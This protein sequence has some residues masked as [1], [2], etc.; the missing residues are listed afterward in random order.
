MERKENTIQIRN[1]YGEILGD[2]KLYEA[3]ASNFTEGTPIV[4]LKY[5]P[6]PKPS[7]RVNIYVK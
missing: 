5:Y 1:S 2:S 3:P 6:L 7:I 4:V